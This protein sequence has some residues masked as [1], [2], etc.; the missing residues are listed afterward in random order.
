MGLDRNLPDISDL[1]VA[2]VLKTMSRLPK[3]L[4]YSF[5]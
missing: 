1:V 4:L 3:S 2:R 5:Q